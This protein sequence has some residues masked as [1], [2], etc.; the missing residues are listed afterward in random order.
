MAAAAT[1]AA[2]V[3]RHDCGTTGF[4]LP[5]LQHKFV[6]TFEREGV[7]WWKSVLKINVVFTYPLILL[8]LLLLGVLKAELQLLLDF[9]F[10]G[11]VVLDE[12]DGVVNDFDLDG[13]VAA[14]FNPA[15][16][17]AGAAAVGVLLAICCFE[18][19]PKQI[20]MHHMRVCNNDVRQQRYGNGFDLDDRKQWLKFCRSI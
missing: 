4:S 19:R 7:F 9:F 11:V 3:W 2:R 15:V 10:V 16:V 5:Q 20:Q 6:E 1:A 18:G 17:C 14:D 13:G 12:D 8:L